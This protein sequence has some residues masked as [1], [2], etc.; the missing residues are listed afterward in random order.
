MRD[1]FQLDLPA[2]S[3]AVAVA[4]AAAAALAEALALPEAKRGR[5]EL[6]VEEAVANAVNH[7]YPD[8]RDGRLRVSAAEEAGALVLGVQDWG[9]PYQPAIPAPGEA[10]EGGGLG[11]LLAF[12][13]ADEARYRPLGREGKRFEFRFRLPAAAPL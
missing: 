1:L 13:M 2:Q 8:G 10:G 7:A 11:L 6:A 12:R 5:L 9:L 3:H 4:R